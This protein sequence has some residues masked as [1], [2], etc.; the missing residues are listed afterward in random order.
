MILGSFIC[1]SST[2]ISSFC[3]SPSQFIFCFGCIFGIGAGLIF[4]A[5]LYSG[6]SHLPERKGLV[7]GIIA[8]GYGMG[9]FMTSL[10]SK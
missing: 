9:A 5:A 7:T 1:I 3:Y 6:W 10:V 2:L 4:P 8:A